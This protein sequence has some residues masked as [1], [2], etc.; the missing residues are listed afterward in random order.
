MI[1]G[2]VVPGG[3]RV[4]IDQTA[5]HLR[6]LG[7]GADVEFGQ[8]PAFDRYDVV[9]GFGLPAT[10]LRQC[11][12]AGMPIVLSTIYWSRDYTAGRTKERWSPRSLLGRIRT[13]ASLFVS[14]VRAAHIE[15]CT[16]VVKRWTDSRV[17][18]ELADLLLPNSDSEAAQMVA[19]L[20]VT[21]PMSVVP[22]AVDDEGFTL[23]KE[24]GQRVGALYVGRFEPHKNQ[25]GLIRAMRS[26][27]IP[28]TLV[29]PPHPHHPGYYARCRR[30]AGG[31]VT[32]LEGVAHEQL[33]DVYARAKVHVLPSWFETTG[34][35]SLEAAL[36]GC[37][38]VTTD[39]GYVRDYF[40]DMAWYC[41]PTDPRSIRA[42]VEAAYAAPF[43]D[44]LREHVLKKYTWKHTAEATLRAYERVRDASRR[45]DLIPACG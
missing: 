25:L 7:V 12:S 40:G 15:K 3:H 34:L 36:C 4:Q 24:S 10:A 13:G 5:R 1:S 32:I 27:G 42:A 8:H 20:G 21:T 18:F 22:N 6:E 39:R 33:R 38:V 35:V 29:G 28:L 2:D 26:S 9:H 14:A 17:Q 31:R 16:D 44:D 19:D 11:R 41:S 37:N 43:R 23:P 30:E 45:S